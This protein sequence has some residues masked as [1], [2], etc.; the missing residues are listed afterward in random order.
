M[1]T[2]K[3]ASYVKPIR[4]IAPNTDHRVHK[5]LNNRIE[6][7]YRLNRKREKIMGRFKSTRSSVL[8][9]TISLPPHTAMQELT[10]SG[11]GQITLRK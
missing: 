6:N 9:A 3:L 4:T 7:S 8:A 11:Y 10:H 1:V 5:G 2:D